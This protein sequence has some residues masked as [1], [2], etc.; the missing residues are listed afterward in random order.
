MKVYV[1]KSMDDFIQQMFPE[2]SKRRAEGLCPLCAKPAKLEDMRDPLSRKE[3]GISG[4]CQ[5]CQ[6]KEFL[7]GFGPGSEFKE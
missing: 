2:E 6:D 7:E 1:F 4:M 5:E 3:F